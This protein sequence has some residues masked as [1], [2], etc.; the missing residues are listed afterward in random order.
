MVEERLETPRSY[1]GYAVFQKP[2][3]ASEREPGILRQRRRSIASN[4]PPVPLLQ[5]GGR[6]IDPHGPPA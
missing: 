6:R 1:H 5:L 2:D 4:E 3:R